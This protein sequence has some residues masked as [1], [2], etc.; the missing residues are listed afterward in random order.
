MNLILKDVKYN[1]EVMYKTKVPKH[2]TTVVANC[3]ICHVCDHGNTNKLMNDLKKKGATNF[4]WE[5]RFTTIGY[6]IYE[7]E[8]LLLNVYTSIAMK[9]LKELYP[10]GLFI[11]FVG[12]H[13]VATPREDDCECA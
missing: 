9:H 7:E 8:D 13:A 11:N 5:P 10:K 1:P 4:C 6:D 3:N 12:D 2:M